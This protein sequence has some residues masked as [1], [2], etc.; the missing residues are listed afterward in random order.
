[1]GE[2]IIVNDLAQS[3]NPNVYAVGDCCSG[4]PRLTHMSAEM[5][6][7]V[8]QN[9]L[10]QDSWRIS[11]LVVPATMYT[12]PEVATVGSMEG[13]VYR[14]GLGDRA[15]LDGSKGFVKIYCKNDQILGATV[16]AERAGEMINEITL[17][18][19]HNL[20]LNA[21]ARNIHCYP[22]LGEAVMGAA[23]SSLQLEKL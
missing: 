17:A 11:S 7:L 2:G 3:S 13:D 14:A 1:M 21:I 20:S 15:L 9:S 12:S 23:S 4:L 10:F 18:M 16:V 6:K 8:V 22:T 5:A 19:K